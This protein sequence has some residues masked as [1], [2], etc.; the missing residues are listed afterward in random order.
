M[1]SPN[2]SGRLFGI[3][4]LLTFLS[5]GVGSSLT[6]LAISNTDLLMH[7][8][9]HKMQLTIG[10]IL[11]AICHTLFNIALPSLMLPILKRFGPA[12][13]Y[14]YYGIVVTATTLLAIGAVFLLLLI[15]MSE[16]QAPLEA[17]AEVVKLGNFYAYQIGMALWGIGGMLF[18]WLLIRSTGI[19][20]LFGVIGVAGYFIFM[21]GTLFELFGFPIGVLLSL[22]G[23]LFEISLSLW[24]IIK[25]FSVKS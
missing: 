4:F 7:V 14:A 20:K 1:Q 9:T 19:P 25:G 18:C 11:M 13:V 17:M 21:T 16:Q 3:F 23:G 22:P 8:A 15:P 10:V 5:Y 6:E 2:R 12:L 24:L